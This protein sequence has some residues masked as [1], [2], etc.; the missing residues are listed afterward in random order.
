MQH[1]PFDENDAQIGDGADQ[2]ERD[3]RDE[4]ERR[5]SLTFAEAE[6]IAE[7]HIGAAEAKRSACFPAATWPWK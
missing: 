7:P 4:H 3:D 1:A 2:R 6:Q 5:V